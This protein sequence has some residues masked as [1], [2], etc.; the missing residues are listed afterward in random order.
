M[1][2]PVDGVSRS[3]GYMLVF[4]VDFNSDTAA[5]DG[6]D[7]VVAHTQ[8]EAHG[9]KEG[10]RVIVN[11]ERER[12]TIPGNVVHIDGDRVFVHCDWFTA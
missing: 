7:C 9:V 11:D 5:I 12:L 1:G 8:P 3:L 10:D 4:E 6:K 2:E